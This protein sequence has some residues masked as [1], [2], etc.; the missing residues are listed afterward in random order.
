MDHHPIKPWKKK[1][2]CN[3]EGEQLLPLSNVAIK[4]LSAPD[5]PSHAKLGRLSMGCLKSRWFQWQWWIMQTFCF[6]IKEW[7]IQQGFNS[8]GNSWNST[9]ALVWYRFPIARFIPVRWSKIDAKPGH[10]CAPTSATMALYAHFLIGSWRNTVCLL[11]FAKKKIE[12]LK[13]L[14]DNISCMFTTFQLFVIFVVVNVTVVV[15]WA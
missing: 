10:P 2:S 13:W 9:N 1:T 5:W 3:R 15:V 14:R 7:R 8:T 12:G 6:P 11:H 4:L